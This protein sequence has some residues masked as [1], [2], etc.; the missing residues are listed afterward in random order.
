MIRSSQWCFA[1][2]RGYGGQLRAVHDQLIAAFGGLCLRLAGS[3]DDIGRVD[4]EPA[5]TAETDAAGHRERAFA[6]FDDVAPVGN[7]NTLRQ[8]LQVGQR[9]AL[10]QHREPPLVDA[11][12]DIVLCQAIADHLGQ[13]GDEGIDGL[14]VEVQVQVFET[15]GLQVQHGSGPF[16]V[17]AGDPGLQ[18]IDE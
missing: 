17:A 14:D 5:D 15:V 3:G 4:H 6:Q 11:C 8:L 7:Q 2:R 12:R 16:A 13:V 18:D 10:S 1:A 9:G